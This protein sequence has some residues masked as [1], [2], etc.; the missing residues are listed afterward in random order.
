M[1]LR[2]YCSVIYNSGCDIWSIILVSKQSERNV[3]WKIEIEWDKGKEGYFFW[4]EDETCPIGYWPTRE[5]AEL[6]LEK[7]EAVKK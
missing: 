7:H 3:M 2:A 4:D 5:Q 1:V 6:E